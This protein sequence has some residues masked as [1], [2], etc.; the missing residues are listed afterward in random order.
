MAIID[1][2][3]PFLFPINPTAQTSAA[4]TYINALIGA[5][6]SFLERYLNRILEDTALAEV[7]NGDGTA[8]IIV[9]RPPINSLTSIV[10]KGTT[11]T[12][13]TST[14]FDFRSE[15]GIIR[16]K[17]HGVT[18]VTNFLGSFPIGFRNIIINYN[19]GYAIIPEPLKLV[20]AEMVIE[21]FDRTSLPSAAQKERL[22][23][24]FIDHGIRHAED[25]LM[26]RKSILSVY[27]LHYA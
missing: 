16:W 25:I 12:T 22:G 26:R 2:G 27:R 17:T 11:D 5:G 10:R 18:D 19:G 21:T 14:N 7:R 20:L 24:Y 6:Q 3:S 4:Q 1:I 9:R 13:I 15:S 8:E 23:Q